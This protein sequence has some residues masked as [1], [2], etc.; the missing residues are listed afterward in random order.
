M[1][2][3]TFNDPSFYVQVMFLECHNTLFNDLY[4]FKI[5]LFSLSLNIVARAGICFDNNGRSLGETC[6][7]RIRKL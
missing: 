2:C 4:F 5:D 3:F 7:K 1:A 6:K